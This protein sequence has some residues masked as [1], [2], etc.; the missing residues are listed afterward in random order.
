M[1]FKWIQKE[2]KDSISKIRVKGECLAKKEMAESNRQDKRIKVIVSKH[3]RF[4]VNMQKQ[5]K[6]EICSYCV[7][8]QTE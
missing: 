6:Q 2:K 8:E 3:K 4:T 5:T 1:H 7:K